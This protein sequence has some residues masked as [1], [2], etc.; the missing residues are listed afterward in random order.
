MVTFR[1]GETFARYINTTNSND[2][3]DVKLSN[4]FV[5]YREDRSVIRFSDVQLGDFGD[6]YH[7]NSEWAMSGTQVGA[8]IWSSPEVLMETPWTTKSLS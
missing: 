4:I 1:P 5:N 8:P 6:S 2:P 7:Q 3:K